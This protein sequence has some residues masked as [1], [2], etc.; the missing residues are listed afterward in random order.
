MLIKMYVKSQ[1]ESETRY[2]PAQC[3]GMETK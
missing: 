2:S 3:I 1:I